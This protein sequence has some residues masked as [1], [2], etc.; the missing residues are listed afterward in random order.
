MLGSFR[1]AGCTVENGFLVGDVREK[2]PKN[3]IVA[4]VF[5]VFPFMV[6]LTELNVC[7]CF[8]VIFFVCLNGCKMTEV[9][10]MDKC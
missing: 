6:R 4:V 3:L 10:M 1:P 8:L 7:G 5:L 9:L 2:T